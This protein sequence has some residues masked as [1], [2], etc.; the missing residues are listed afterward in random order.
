MCNIAYFSSVG[1]LVG[2]VTVCDP[3]S[4]CCPLLG[5]GRPPTQLPS[6]PRPASVPQRAAQQATVPSTLLV[7]QNYLLDFMDT[8]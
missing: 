1:Y 2:Q 6:P 4:Y 5:T 7:S 3:G 8:L